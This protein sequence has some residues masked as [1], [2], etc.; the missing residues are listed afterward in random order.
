MDSTVRQMTVLVVD[1]D[2]GIRDSM[3]D[4]LC[5][6]GYDA[7]TARSAELALEM[8]QKRDYDVIVLDINLPGM[9][10]IQALKQ[11]KASDPSPRVIMVTGSNSDATTA[12][13]LDAGADAL[14]RKP[15]DV[16]SFLPVLMS[17]DAMPENPE[18]N[19]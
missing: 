1:D 6:E 15:L 9:D 11:I 19:L 10:G 5:I 17:A 2:A 8:A 16:A 7:D 18:E 13:A 14:F 4:V 12:A 3:R